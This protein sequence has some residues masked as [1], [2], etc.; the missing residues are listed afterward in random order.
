MLNRK[1]KLREETHGGLM[2]AGVA[3]KTVCADL[4]SNAD[5]HARSGEIRGPTHSR[6]AR[7]AARSI[8]RT[9]LSDS[10]IRRDFDPALGAVR[11]NPSTPCRQSNTCRPNIRD[12]RAVCS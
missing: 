9:T 10:E 4:W 8:A 11:P 6:V 5:R 12:P 7:P 2:G 1:Q 3:L